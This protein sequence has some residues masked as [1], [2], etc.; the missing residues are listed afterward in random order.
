MRFDGEVSHV[1]SITFSDPEKAKAE[2]I[3]GDWSDYF[4]EIDD[5]E[6]LATNII[7][8]VHNEQEISEIDSQDKYVMKRSPE[9]FGVYLKDGNDWVM[10]NE[11]TGK[12]T[13]TIYSLEVFVQEF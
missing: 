8:A 7:Q 13:V 4:W 5:M 11:H 12:I 6:D 3:D 2:F 9:G 10:D 1:T